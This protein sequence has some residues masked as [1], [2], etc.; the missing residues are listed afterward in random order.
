MH[1]KSFT[2]QFNEIAYY[3][4]LLISTM[5]IIY[6]EVKPC[7]DSPLLIINQKGTTKASHSC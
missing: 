5:K 2:K 4:Y 1:Q 6:L 3:I 7:S